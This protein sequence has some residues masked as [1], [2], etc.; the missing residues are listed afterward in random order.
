MSSSDQNDPSNVPESAPQETGHRSGGGPPSTGKSE[1]DRSPASRFREQAAS[2]QSGADN[3]D[4]EEERELWR[5]GYSGKAMVGTW[6]LLA[7]AGV[8]L[9]ILPF[10]VPGIPFLVVLGLVLLA[11]VVGGCVYT[12]RRLAVHYELTNQRFVHQAGLLTRR[13]DRIEVID[14]D[15]VAC[16]Q[17]PVQRAFGVGTIVLTGSDRTHP[18]LSMI[19]IADVRDVASLI[20]DT[21]RK[22]RRRR[23]LHIEAI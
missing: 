3:H 9:L 12:Y 17:G 23:S 4:D 14:I 2:R 21:R 18:R 16:T 7:V 13:T 22:E 20:D 8:A 1:S 10:F 19:G 11:W 15:D 5:G 6:I